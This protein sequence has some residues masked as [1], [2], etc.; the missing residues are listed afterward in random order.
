MLAKA[1]VPLAAV[2]PHLAAPLTPAQEA[3]ARS[4]HAGKPGPC[5]GNLVRVPRPALNSPCTHTE[6]RAA[7]LKCFQDEKKC[8]EVTGGVWKGQA[9]AADVRYT[10]RPTA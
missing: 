3:P 4:L 2:A 9:D 7:R 10:M 5:H 1:A 6:H 8:G